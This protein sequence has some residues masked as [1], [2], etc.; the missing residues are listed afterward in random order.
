MESG[1]DAR[2]AGPKGPLYRRVG[3]EDPRRPQSRADKWYELLVTGSDGVG[4]LSKLTGVFARHE[5]N[6]GPSGEYY[7]GPSGE[8]AWTTFAN[9]SNSQ[10]PIERVVKELQK[11]EFVAR[12]DSVKVQEI[13]IERFLFPVMIT[14]KFRGLILNLEPL[15]GVERRLLETFGSAGAALM[16]EEGRQY[17]IESLRQLREVQP[18]SEPHDFLDFVISWLRT[19]GWGVFEFDTRRFDGSGA[20]KVRVL[21]PPNAVVSGLLQSNFTNGATAGIIEV[22]YG[23]AMRIVE[24]A[25]EESKRALRLTFETVEPGLRGGPP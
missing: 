22:I 17:A 7:T 24:S 21:E 8:F 3:G 1:I 12:V 5:V 14:E 9:F 4:A 11:F 18:G 20:V 10:S 15:L 6:L 23:R 16:F 19:T 13:A 2:L 25:Y